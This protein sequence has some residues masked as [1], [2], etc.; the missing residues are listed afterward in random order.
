MSA[1]YN[2]LFLCT[3]NSARS[4]MPE[5]ILNHKAKGAFTAYNAGSF[6]SLRLYGFRNGSGFDFPRKPCQSQ[7]RNAGGGTE[8]SLEQGLTVGGCS[9][10]TGV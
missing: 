6:T 7:V 5:A 1:H 8:S 10:R 9:Y 4:I 2:V 3:S